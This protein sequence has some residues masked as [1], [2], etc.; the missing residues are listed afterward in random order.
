MKKTFLVILFLLCSLL[1]FAACG[2]TAD[3]E[4]DTRSVPDESNEID[5]ESII[6]EYETEIQKAIGEKDA[7]A[8]VSVI[9]DY[10][11]SDLDNALDPVVEH[12]FSELADVEDYSNFEFMRH[13]VAGLGDISEA[14][15]LKAICDEKYLNEVKGFLATSWVRKDATALDGI[16]LKVVFS[17]SANVGILT[18]INNAIDPSMWAIGDI[19]W[20]NIGIIDRNTIKLSDLSGDGE[21]TNALCTLDYDNFSI[22]LHSNVASNLL[23]SYLGGDQF[24]I[25][26][27]FYN[28][29]GVD[30]TL[31]Q[32]DFIVKNDS[33]EEESIDGGE[34]FW[35]WFCYDN[36]LVSNPVDEEKNDNW[37]TRRGIEIG[38][39][40][41]D[42]IS[43]YGLGGKNI[44][45]TSNDAMLIFAETYLKDYGDDQTFTNLKELLSTKAKSFIQYMDENHVKRL[46]FYFDDTDKVVL[47]MYCG[48]EVAY[49]LVQYTNDTDVWWEIEW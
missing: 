13:T 36:S 23:L 15:T 46:R 22:S 35:G 25:R 6:K 39:S 29:C 47:F 18:E 19:K 14:Q 38:S 16:I 8:L 44:V 30:S 45:N 1:V 43:A 3:T 49:H 32:D 26:E 31:S 27:D 7:D 12:S 20:D 4:T 28:N 34:G 9:N 40:L 42:V 41:D 5:I 2:S 17:D 10:K 11:D 33:G 24:W 48:D 21:Y 37:T